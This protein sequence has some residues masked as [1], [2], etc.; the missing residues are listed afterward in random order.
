MLIK[1]GLLIDG[2][3]ALPGIDRFIAVDNGKIVAVGGEDDFAAAQVEQAVDYSPYT[4]LP[5]LIDSHVHLF[6]EGIDDIEKRRCR[7]RE[8][9]EI[10]LFR[11]ARNL[12]LT[13]RKGVTTVRD[14]GGPY[15]IA[16]TLKR[17]VS[18][19]KILGPRVLTCHRSISVPGGHFHYAG[20]REAAGPEEIAQAVR[21]QIAAG[22]DCVKLMA[23]GLVDFRT[24]QTGV[25]E[26]S[27]DDIE[28]AVAEAQRLGRPVS[29]HAN[30]AVGVRSA[31]IAKV[32]TIEHGILMGEKTVDLFG[33]GPAYWVPTLSPLRQMLACSKSH[34]AAT[35]P[36]AGLERIY[37]GHYALVSR[38][39][40]AGS[41]I[42]AGTDAG[43]L[44]V[45]HGE[46][47]QELALLAACGLSPLA[48][49]QAATGK[50]ASAVGVGDFT[51]TIEPGKAAD[52]LVIR[53]N[54]LD[55][56]GFLRNVVQVF[57]EGVNIF[58]DSQAV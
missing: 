56:M 31:L 47:W 17:A 26:L 22:A 29:V 33:E 36:E 58:A 16:T 4:V 40:N 11:A 10:M 49:I 53:G 2:S 48:A 28:A 25:P 51:G 3:G 7:L 42:I 1:A 35:M 23:T 6:L 32:D 30:G 44:G 39:I 9:R 37:N 8:G 19:K 43:S 54:P 52:L 12:E 20:G 38:G 46:V 14:L 57:K 5:G 41:G 34:P 50:S 13:L 24:E 45:A 18:E 15:G 27:S 21:E 55:N